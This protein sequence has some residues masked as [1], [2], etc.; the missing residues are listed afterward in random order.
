M[1]WGASILRQLSAFIV[2]LYFLLVIPRLKVQQWCIDNEF[3]LI[4]TEP[5]QPDDEDGWLT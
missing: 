3:E 2:P 5:A 4:E 1:F